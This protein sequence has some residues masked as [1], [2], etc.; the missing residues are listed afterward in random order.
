MTIHLKLAAMALALAITAGPAMADTTST[1]PGNPCAKDNGNPCNG[2]NGNLGEQGNANHEKVKID[3]HPPPIDLPMPAVS[4]RAAFIDQIGD[5]NIATVRQIAPNAFAR[6]DQE[7]TS[8]EADITQG[9]TGSAYAEALQEGAGNFGRIQQGGS[10]QNVVYL[11]Q[12]GVGNWA[13]SNQD[14]I[15]AIHNGARMTQIGN[16]NDMAL[17]QNGSDNRA[18][19]SQEGDGNGMTAVQAGDG[20]R[21]IWTQQGSNLTDLQITQ[22]G[23]SEKGGQLLVT[24]TGINPGG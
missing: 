20:N 18:L 23:G 24:Q 12:H 9:G 16:N 14:A 21:L 4:G 22:T 19:L 2:N 15:G 5:A 1:P 7:G 3:K 6:V 8:N 13:W 11:T 10:G 17:V